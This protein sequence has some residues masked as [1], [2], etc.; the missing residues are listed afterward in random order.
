M[1][2]H[3]DQIG[4]FDPSFLLRNVATVATAADQYVVP[5]KWRS[6]ISLE[7]P[8]AIAMTGNNSPVF[9]DV[10]ARWIPLLETADRFG[11]PRGPAAALV[12]NYRGPYAGSNWGLVGVTNRDLLNGDFPVAED[13]MRRCLSL[14]MFAEM[15]DEQIDYVGATLRSVMDGNAAFFRSAT[16]DAASFE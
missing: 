5:E 6:E 3:P 1:K 11:R 12:L 2:L 16:E 14:P 15:E 8:A 10:Q 4:V 13:V 7:G 9:P